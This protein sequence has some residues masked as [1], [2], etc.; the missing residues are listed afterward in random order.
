MHATPLTVGSDSSIGGDAKG[1]HPQ[2]TIATVRLD[3]AL[4][5]NLAATAA[6]GFDDIEL[7]DPDLVAS[8]LAPEHMR[9]SLTPDPI[10]GVV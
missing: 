2:T 4:E 7:W 6:T 9:P 10:C 5:G 3:G 8:T 1:F